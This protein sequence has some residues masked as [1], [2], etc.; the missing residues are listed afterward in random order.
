ME[1]NW[2]AILVIT[3]AAFA[4]GAL[5]HGPLFGKIWMKIHHGDKVFSKEE[6]VELSKG[7]WKLLLTEFVATLLMIISLA[8][9]VKAIPQY[10]GVQ[11]GFMTWLGFVLPMTV[12]NI[13]WGGDK[14][15]WWCKK[16]LISV[17]Y[18]LLVF[19]AAGY[20]LS[21]WL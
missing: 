4:G 6:M 13:I 11:V 3:F 20:I 2:I 21:I 19:L 7:M 5:W 16:I 10:S 1:L 15:E 14:R 17:S 8:C 18:R 9:L 12:S